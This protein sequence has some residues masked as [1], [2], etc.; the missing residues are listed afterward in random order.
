MTNQNRFLKRSLV[1]SKSKF[2]YN[3]EWINILEGSQGSYLWV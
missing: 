2:Q 3:P 1:H